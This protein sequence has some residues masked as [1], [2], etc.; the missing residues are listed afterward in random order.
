MP[1]AKSR[2]KSQDKFLI[3]Q[4]AFKLILLI[5]LTLGLSIS[6][7]SLLA[8]WTAPLASPPGCTAGNPGCDAPLNIGPLMQVK[9]G[10]LWLNTNG[11][12]PYGLIIE[13]GNVGIG[14]TN[15]SYPLQIIS[16]SPST[17]KTKLGLKDSSTDGTALIRFENNNYSWSAGIRN[18]KNQCDI[19]GCRD[20]DSDLVVYNGRRDAYEFVIKAVSGNVGIGT[21][22]PSYPLQ[23]ISPSPSTSKTKLGLKDSS[24]DGTALI[25]FENNN[26]SWSAGIRNEKNQCDINGCRDFDSDLVVYNGRRDAYEFIIKSASGSVGVG[27]MP[28]FKFDVNGNIRVNNNIT[29]TGGLYLAGDLSPSNIILNAAG[30]NVGIGTASPGSY[31]LNVA[32]TIYTSGGCTGCS[33]IRWKKNIAPIN[34]SLALVSQ[35]QGVRFNWRSDEYPKMFFGNSTD[36]GLIAQ[37]VE[38]VMPEL[39]YEVDGYKYLKYERLVPLLIEAVKAQQKQIDEL[40]TKLEAELR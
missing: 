9:S 23:I 20:F 1:H 16:P 30:G 4:Q 11:I 33:D 26:Y 17:S 22:S 10:A 15:P 38:K 6:L 29:G 14:T 28:L 7:Q 36:V 5:I 19:N 2:P 8:A 34:D 25:R 24:T 40:K 12:S 3:F 37:D 31:K 18:E 35:L 13:K 32:G 21:A 39:I 27:M